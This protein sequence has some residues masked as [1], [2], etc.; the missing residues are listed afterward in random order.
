MEALVALV[1]R[2]LFAAAYEAFAV[3]QIAAHRAG[4]G[5]ETVV[6]LDLIRSL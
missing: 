5:G 6:P 4:P 3:P 2:L 1:S